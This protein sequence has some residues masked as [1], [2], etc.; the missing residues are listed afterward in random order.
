MTQLQEAPRRAP[1]LTTGIVALVAAAVIA[2]TIVLGML[3][4]GRVS[5][6]TTG[7]GEGQG[8]AKPALVDAEREWQRQREQ[9]GGF[10]DPL[11]QAGR[12]WESQRKQQ[13]PFDGE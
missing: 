13:S 8:Q 11:T 2:V 3:I 5:L 9:Q 4:P 6:P 7:A 12:D 1:I 10:T